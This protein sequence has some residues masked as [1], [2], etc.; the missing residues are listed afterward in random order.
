MAIYTEN[1]VPL[2][3][4]KLSASSM[5]FIDGKHE[6][7]QAA[8]EKKGPDAYQKELLLGE[9]VIVHN[10]APVG[11]GVRVEDGQ[12]QVLE[13]DVPD[14]TF[15][16]IG[17]STLQEAL[18]EVIGAYDRIHLQTQDNLDPPDWVASTHEDLANLLAEYYGCEVRPISEV[19]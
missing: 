7:A 4:H 5:E 3:S 13:P 14:R 1:D 10:K 18:T 8:L 16:S 12:A 11:G 6:K 19:M 9:G 17:A 15:F 2:L